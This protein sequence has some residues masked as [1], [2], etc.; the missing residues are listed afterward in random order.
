[1]GIRDERKKRK[2]ER[3]KAI[4]E[5]LTNVMFHLIHSGIEINQ[6]RSLTYKDTVKNLHGVFID[7]IQQ[8]ESRAVPQERQLWEKAAEK[9]LVEFQKNTKL[10]Q[11]DFICEKK[12]LPLKTLRIERIK[13]MKWL[14]SEEK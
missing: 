12:W 4:V 5:I 3:I 9:I 1:M 2:Q 11:M 8:V 7:F 13:K 10:V 6:A 14:A